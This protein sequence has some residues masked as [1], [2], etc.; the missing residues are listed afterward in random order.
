MSENTTT[1]CLKVR[2][3]LRMYEQCKQ[4]HVIEE[5]DEALIILTISGL[6]DEVISGLEILNKENII[7]T[8]HK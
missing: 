4:N 1:A 6:V 5:N 2:A 7:A 3:I 8:K